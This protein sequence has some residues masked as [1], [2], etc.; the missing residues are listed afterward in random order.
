LETLVT[1]ID[2]TA[3]LAER[4]NQTAE[5]VSEQWASELKKKSAI[6]A[7]AN[8]LTGALRLLIKLPRRSTD[9]EMSSFR[10]PE[11]QAVTQELTQWVAWLKHFVRVDRADFV[12]TVRQEANEFEAYATKPTDAVAAVFRKVA[13]DLETAKD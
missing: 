8:A 4:L 10:P 6:N 7:V 12:S 13:H 3:Q 1:E 2:S 5:T 11:L 9:R